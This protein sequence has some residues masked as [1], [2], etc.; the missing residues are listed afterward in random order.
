MAKIN[1]GA[2]SQNNVFEL[3]LAENLQ[4]ISTFTAN[5]NV[6]WSING[7]DDSDKFAL[8][9]S[10]GELSFVSIPD[11]EN[12]TDSDN[13]NNYVVNI[14]ATDTSGN[15]T[16]GIATITITDF[17]E[18]S[19]ITGFSG[20][21]GDL[22]SEISINEKLLSIGQLTASE[23]VTWSIIGGADSNKFT[24][25][26]ST[27]DLTFSITTDYELPRDVDRTPFCSS[28][29]DSVNLSSSQL[30]FQLSI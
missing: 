13:S 1:L 16:S 20:E 9:E 22:T 8:D 7:G 18:V 23:T 12:A 11:Y 15:E 6:T 24:L 5:E 25:D 4:S 3:N 21:A 14:K 10:T 26:E 28:A 30:V 29:T 19:P 17:D 27:G 2:S